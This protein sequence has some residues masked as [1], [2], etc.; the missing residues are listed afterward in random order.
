MTRATRGHTGRA[1]S[2]DPATVAIYAV[3]NLAALCRVAAPFV[4][5]QHIALL[6]ASAILWSLAFGGF[7]LAYGRMLATPR[8]ARA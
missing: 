3:I 2:A 1:L 6:T 4:P 8:P 5:A 7:A